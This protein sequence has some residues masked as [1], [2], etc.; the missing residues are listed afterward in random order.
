M[1]GEFGID[2]VCVIPNGVA[3]A[4]YDAIPNKPVVDHLVYCGTMDAFINQ[5]AVTWFIR[6]IFPLILKRKP[7]ATFTVIGKGVPDS[8]LKLAS[9]KIR[10]TGNVPD[11]RLPLKDGMLEV[12]PLR[13]AGGSRLKILEAFAAKIPVLSTP[14][15]AEGL[16]VEDGKSIV[17]ADTPETFANECVRILDDTNLRQ[18]LVAEGRA[19]VDRQYDW[20]RISP[21]VEEVW[22]YTVQNQKPR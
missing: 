9:D 7:G 10:F 16:D 11:I 19:I 3:I 2:N 1:R 6:S 15:G 8:L 4:P 18:K 17:L 13:I 5:D 14:I 22:Q 12:V 20:S 21:L